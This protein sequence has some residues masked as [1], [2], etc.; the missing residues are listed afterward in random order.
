[1]NKRLKD[2]T[3]NKT[4]MKEINKSNLSPLMS[5]TLWFSL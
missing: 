1:M 4:Q 2:W 5:Q 3:T